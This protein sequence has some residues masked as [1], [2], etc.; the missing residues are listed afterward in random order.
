V[1]SAQFRWVEHEGADLDALA[2]GDA[3]RGGRIVEGGMGGEAGAAVLLRIVAFQQHGLV[4]AL[5]WEIEPAVCR[6]VG[7]GIGL[8]VEVGVVLEFESIVVETE[9]IVQ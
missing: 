9:L 6:V 3:G 4:G 2:R 1:I 5:A 8:V 7:D